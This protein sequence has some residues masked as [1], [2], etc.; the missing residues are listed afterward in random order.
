MWCAR[1]QMKHLTRLIGLVCT[2]YFQKQ[3]A[4]KDERFCFERV[5]MHVKEAARLPYH[6]DRFFKSFCGKNF[7]KNFSFHFCSLR[8]EGTNTHHDTAILTIFKKMSVEPHDSVCGWRM[9]Q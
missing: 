3:L 1:R 6:G 8:V 7:H 5:G 9:T 2:F 4:F